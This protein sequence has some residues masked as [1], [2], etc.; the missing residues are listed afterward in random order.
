MMKGYSIENYI[1]PPYHKLQGHKN[2]MCDSQGIPEPGSIPKS[3]L[4]WTQS[5]A[6]NLNCICQMTE[7]T[8]MYINAQERN[9]IKQN[10]MHK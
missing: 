4:V 5:N 2:G 6:N 3:K 7:P 9:S 10:R 1:C 8:F